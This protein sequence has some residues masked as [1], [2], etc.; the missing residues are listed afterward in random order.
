MKG[1]GG[2]EKEHGGKGRTPA[3]NREKGAEGRGGKTHFQNSGSFLISSE[4]AHS[5]LTQIIRK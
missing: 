2:Q 1:K 3:G 5:F 4:R